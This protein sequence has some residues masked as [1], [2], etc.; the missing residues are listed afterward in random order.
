MASLDAI[1]LALMAVIETYVDE[2]LHIYSYPA[3]TGNLPAVVI[4]E[5]G[6]DYLQALDRGSNEWTFEVAVMVPRGE[7][8]ESIRE[9]ARQTS[10]AAVTTNR[11]TESAG[12]T[13][14]AVAG[15]S[16]ASGEVGDIVKLITQI[17]EQTNLL[18]LN[19]T[20]EA[21]RAG[22]AGRGFAV[23]AGEVRLL[24]LLTKADKFGRG[25]QTQALMAVKREL[26][27]AFGDTVSV[28]TFSGESKQG[29]DEARAVVAGWLGLSV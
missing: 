3:E 12:E 6:G 19:A 21:A 25:Q 1:A 22:E 24:A 15:L 16:A 2:P 29:V 7:L 18:A 10:D 27:S 17:A 26:F 4:G 14:S 11:A 23:V 9:I 5:T 8:S 20:I 28:Q 13:A